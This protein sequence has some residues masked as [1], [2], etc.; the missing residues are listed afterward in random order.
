MRRG[1]TLI[2]LLV[3]IAIIAILAA[4]LFPVFARAR[5]KARTASCQSNLKQISLAVIMY[6]TDYDQTYPQNWTGNCSWGAGAD[7]MEVTQPY[8]KNWTLYRCPSLTM[9]APMSS[10]G[11]FIHSCKMGNRRSLVGRQ[12]GYAINAAR[13]DIGASA[14][15]GWGPGGN[16]LWQVKTEGMIP[17]PAETVMLAETNLGCTMLCGS[18]HANFWNPWGVPIFSNIRM[19]HNEGINLA[20]TDGHVKWMSKAAI[21]ADPTMWGKT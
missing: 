14:H 10:E 4:I 13:A 17:K 7:W 16:S 5:E 21:D 1:F 11:L 2:E 15:K 18:W 20:F 9:S 6:S 12:G 3:V 8:S 19:E